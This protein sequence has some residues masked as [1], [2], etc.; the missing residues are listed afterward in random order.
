M[1]SGLPIMSATAQTDTLIRHDIF[2]NSVPDLDLIHL[3]ATAIQLTLAG[4]PV[5]FLAAY[6][7]PSHSLIGADLTVSFGGGL[8]AFLTGYLT[9]KHADWK[10]WLST[11]WGKI[12]CDYADENSCLIFGPNTQTTNPFNPSTTLDVLDIVITWHIASLVYLF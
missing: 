1:H 6:I 9:A 4:N 11:R 8:P 10:S 12:L 5:E 3:E 2:H 7:S